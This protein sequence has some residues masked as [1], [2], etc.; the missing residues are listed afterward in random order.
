MMQASLG[1]ALALLAS[2][3]HADRW[4][5]VP[6]AAQTRFAEVAPRV[7]AGWPLALAWAVARLYALMPSWRWLAKPLALR[8]ALVEASCAAVLAPFLLERGTPGRI[9]LGAIVTVSAVGALYGLFGDERNR[10]GPVLAGADAV[11]PHSTKLWGLQGLAA[12]AWGAALVL[13]GETWTH[14]APTPELSAE[15][16]WTAVWGLLLIGLGLLSWL[17]AGPQKILEG[18]HPDASFVQFARLFAVA[19]ALVGLAPLGGVALFALLTEGPPRP[20]GSGLLTGLAAIPFALANGALLLRRDWMSKRIEWVQ[21]RIG[22]LWL[23]QFVFYVGPGLL[24]LLAWRQISEDL[25]D[26]GPADAASATVA[27][28]GCNAVFLIGALAMAMAVVTLQ[29]IERAELVH[30]RMFARGF[31]VWCITWLAVVLYNMSGHFGAYAARYTLAGIGATIPVV[32]VTAPNVLASIPPAIGPKSVLETGDADTRP[33]MLL[34]LWLGQGIGIAVAAIAFAFVPERV[35]ALIAAH[36]EPPAIWEL[37][38]MRI[39]APYYAFFAYLSFAGMT[40]MNR[41]MWRAIARQF[42]FWSATMLAAYVFVYNTIVYSR[43]ALMGPGAMLAI[44]V[45]NLWLLRRTS[46]SEDLGIAPGP[47]GLGEGDLVVAAPMA[48]QVVQKKK[49]AS[50]LY[51]AGAQ[52]ALLVTIPAPSD[53]RFPQNDFF[54]AHRG[55]TCPVTMRF[56]NLTNEDD[57]SL[58][59][60]GAALRIGHEDDPERFD[61]VFNTGSFAPPQNLYEFASFVVS[62]W[63]PTSVSRAAI[64]GNPIFFEGGVAGLRRAPESY[65]KLFYYSQ[66]V[67]IWVGV[68]GATAL[69]EPPEPLR[70]FEGLRRMFL[71]RYRLAP[72]ALLPDAPGVPPESYPL[73]AYEVESGLPDDTD[74]AAMWIRS[75]RPDERRPKD[76]L[77]RG[78]MQALARG[79]PVRF[80]LQ[81]QFHEVEEPDGKTGDA[82]AWY[83]AGVDWDEDTCPWRDLG[84]IS[85]T[86]ALGDAE[87]ERLWFNPGKHPLSMGI[88]ASP[89]PSDYRSLGDAEVRV[90]RALS[91]LRE[92]MQRWGGAR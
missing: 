5:F 55:A 58:D 30:R 61:L 31:S 2:S 80:A 53:P 29:A 60:R 70:S 35:A 74:T 33:R 38:Q 49:R 64:R 27:G 32:L 86:R 48:I 57:A 45:V 11:G 26:G 82:L 23:A 42:V 24:W 72:L 43:A 25:R 81:A 3:L 47:I 91:L 9:V 19:F 50:H 20:L 12:V 88:P 16:P 7:A 4:S 8:M 18:R 84:V 56:A 90:M 52:G 10:P 83:N 78:L 89:G 15:A 87:T 79:E 40:Q 46:V 75:R 13:R 41:W 69:L 71:V 17:G 1:V 67:R 51:G 59:V 76:Y 62:K 37:D 65:A 34:L 63:A 39:H 54:H 28:F 68:R 14:A 92:R 85:L 77:R 36:D 6:A 21:E 44:L 73:S 22:G 66:I